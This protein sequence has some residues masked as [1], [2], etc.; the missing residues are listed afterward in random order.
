MLVKIDV[1]LFDVQKK[2][3][4][5]HGKHHNECWVNNVVWTAD[6]E[7][8]LFSCRPNTHS[9]KPVVFVGNSNAELAKA[10]AIIASR[11]NDK[12]GRQTNLAEPG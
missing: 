8:F 5:S 1:W 7:T 3:E 11:N 12:G 10:K 2:K 4:R 9:M 6:N